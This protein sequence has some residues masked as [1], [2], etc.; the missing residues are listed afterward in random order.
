MDVGH[1]CPHR[2][3]R[4][5]PHGARRPHTRPVHHPENSLTTAPNPQADPARNAALLRVAADRLQAADA[6]ADQTIQLLSSLLGEDGVLAVA[7]RLAAQAVRALDPV[8][9]V[10][11]RDPYAHAP[12]VRTHLVAVAEAIKAGLAAVEEDSDELLKGLRAWAAMSP[13]EIAAA[14]G[15]FDPRPRSVGGVPERLYLFWVDGSDHGPYPGMVGPAHTTGSLGAYCTAGF[16]RAVAERIVD[17]LH[18][19]NCGLTA[20]WQDD[21]AL[22]FTWSVD[23]DGVGGTEERWPDERGHYRI[24]GLWP[25]DYSSVPAP[26]PVPRLAAARAHSRARA[27]S[28]PQLATATVPAAAPAPAA[29]PAVRKSL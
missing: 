20:T 7:S 24:G 5:D 27:D 10:G 6:D 2:R 18:A 3:G 15:D 8:I 28:A 1:R 26:E 17:D 22:R 23:Y 16:T 11:L 25:W 9:P 19:D 12:Q 21:G 4:T 14:K 29:V 13:A